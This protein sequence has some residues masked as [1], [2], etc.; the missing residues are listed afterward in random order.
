[1]P[2]LIRYSNFLPKSEGPITG[3]RKIWW[4]GEVRVINDATRA[5]KL[6]KCNKGWEIDGAGTGTDLDA[7]PGLV[8][9]GWE[10]R[11]DRAA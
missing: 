3:I 8:S 9:G 10:S 2:T 5:A 7:L 1:M 11:R 6:W 4:P